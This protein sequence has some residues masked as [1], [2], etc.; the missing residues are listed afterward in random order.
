MPLLTHHAG[1]YKMYNVFQT[2]QSI[3][4]PIDILNIPLHLEVP[5]SFFL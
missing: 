5:G 2:Q 3:D 1:D 4:R